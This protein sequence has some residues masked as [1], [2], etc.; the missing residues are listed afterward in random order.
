MRRSDREISDRGRIDD[1]IR[2][3]QVC[4]LALCENDQPYVVP[5][6]FGYDG[7]YLY[8]H[9]APEGK[10]LDILRKNGRV[11]FAFDILHSIITSERACNWGA[12]YESVIGSGTA[13]M[14]DTSEEKRIALGA[15]M[16]QYGGE[17]AYLSEEEIRQVAVVRVRIDS[18]TG[19]ARQLPS[20]AN[21]A[22]KPPGAKQAR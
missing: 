2:R 4:H 17:A 5:L 21:R 1:I 15:I 9:S 13:E 8:F 11:A 7:R 20:S 14:V 16:R 22:V 19:K 18:V 6:N 10:K 12:A 3:A